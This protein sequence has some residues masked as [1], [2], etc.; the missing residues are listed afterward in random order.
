MQLT[1]ILNVVNRDTGSKTGRFLAGAVLGAVVG[2]LVA[3]LIVVSLGEPLV[4]YVT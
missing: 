2:G 1:D 4:S 3:G